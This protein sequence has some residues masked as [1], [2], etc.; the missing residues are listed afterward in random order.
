MPGYNCL[1]THRDG[2]DRWIVRGDLDIEGT[3]TLK[4]GHT[5]AVEDTYW[6]D[7]H[8]T[9]LASKTGGA[10]DPTFTKL[11]D[12]G[13]GSQGVNTYDFSNST[14][15]ELFAVTQFPHHW[16][17]GTALEPHVHYTVK[18]EATGVVKWGLEYTVAGY[19]ENF[20]LS[21]IIYAEETVSALAA[22]DHTL[23][24]FPSI[25]LPT[26]TLSSILMLRFFRPINVV[27]MVAAD[28]S[29]LQFDFH[30]QIDG[31]GSRETFVK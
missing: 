26:A 30:H 19:G 4:D 15:K 14:E 27:D 2:G 5:L 10:K 29:L 9:L 7:L 22:L 21:T 31:F 12:D 23:V 3:L 28:L 17:I 13:A 20:G 16:K 25:P 11:T 24:S 6:D 1:N 18:A 8:V